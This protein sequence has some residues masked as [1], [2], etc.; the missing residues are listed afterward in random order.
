[1]Q[2]I[3]NHGPI[4]A[5]QKANR[6]ANRLADDDVDAEPANQELLDR[7]LLDPQLFNLDQLVGQILDRPLGLI[8]PLLLQI[9][10]QV[11]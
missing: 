8:G 11:D 3:N 9:N 4:A 1:M 6:L 2:K 5:A 7:Q 10:R